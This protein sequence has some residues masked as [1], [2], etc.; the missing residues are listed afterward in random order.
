MAEGFDV[1]RL[2]GDKETTNP[3]LQDKCRAVILDASGIENS[4]DLRKKLNL[5]GPLIDFLTKQFGSDDFFI[6]KDDVTAEDISTETY[7][8]TC[9]LDKR[10]VLL[11]CI[12]N[13]ILSEENREKIQAWRKKDLKGIQRCLVS[14]QEGQKEIFIL[15][16]GLHGLKD[17][18]GIMKG[19]DMRPDEISIWYLMKR[20]AEI[21]QSLQEKKLQYQELDMSKICITS[22]GDVCMYNPIRY[23]SENP[24]NDPFAISESGSSVIYTPPEVISGEQ[25]TIKSD[26][27]IVGCVLYEVAMQKPAYSVTGTDIFAS[28]N[29]IVEGKMPETLDSDY[30]KELQKILTSCLHVQMQG[31]PG[32]ETLLQKAEEKLKDGAYDFSK[33]LKS[34]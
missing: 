3:T 12:P 32:L 4:A 18:I 25:P 19:K 9:M 8:A 14:F 26:I 29:E 20:V 13:R 34:Q 27:W 28:L 33:W 17:I 16:G 31:R 21:L 1:H 11:K 30:S 15:E 10:N 24:N 22:T 5:P 2:T 6:N 7:K 23:I